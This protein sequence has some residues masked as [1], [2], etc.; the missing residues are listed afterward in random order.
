[1][2]KKLIILISL[3]FLVVGSTSIE[4]SDKNAPSTSK[5]TTNQIEK[6]A[7]VPTI[8]E[9]TSENNKDVSSETKTKE[10]FKCNLQENKVVTDISNIHITFEEAPSEY[11]KK[12]SWGEYEK[13]FPE[14]ELINIKK[15]IIQGSNPTLQE[16]YKKDTTSYVFTYWA[17][18]YLAHSLWASFDNRLW[19]SSINGLVVWRFESIETAKM[20]YDNY[21]KMIKETSTKREVS[22]TLGEE[23]VGWCSGNCGSGKYA[24]MSRR[25]NIIIT[26]GGGVSMSTLEKYGLLLD[27]RIC[28]S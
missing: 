19:G 3:L 28:N 8:S 18:D 9:K 5:I 2:I 22:T 25:N 16:N 21:L 14:P 6:S 24:L 11:Y 23:V 10:I 7:D 1:M 20:I 15:D 4:Q 17:E 13:K 27:Q 12:N 26:L